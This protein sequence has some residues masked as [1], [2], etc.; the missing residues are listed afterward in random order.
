M[1]CDCPDVLSEFNL[2]YIITNIFYYTKDSLYYSYVIQLI[3]VS[4]GYL[5]FGKG[6]Y[7]KTLLVASCTGLAGAVL[8]KI[9]VVWTD[10]P[11][12]AD[13]EFI[14]ILLLLNEPCWIITEFAIPYL[15]M[16]KLNAVLAKNRQLTLK[17]FTLITFILFSIFRFRIG[18]LRFSSHTV[19][20]EEIFHAH[21]FSFG[22]MATTEF[23]FSIF[24]IKKMTKDVKMAKERGVDGNIYDKS[25][26]SSLTILLL[27]DICG[28]ILAILSM[29]SNDTL[30]K[31]LKPF[32]CI[33]SNSI[34]ILAFDSIV[35]KL[36]AKNNGFSTTNTRDNSNQ[37][38]TETSN[39][40]QTIDNGYYNSYINE[41]PNK[42]EVH[43]ND[44]KLNTEKL[45][46]IN[47]Q[48]LNNISNLAYLPNNGSNSSLNS[49]PMTTFS[50]NT[51]KEIGII[52]TSNKNTSENF[53]KYAR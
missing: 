3:L 33:K 7:W 40:F 14:Y 47:E 11:K 18:Y 35:L 21:G 45:G 2:G 28:I 9:C 34:L 6:K 44:Q 39:F 26:K 19:F 22:T 16:I 5:R 24:I 20:N 52:Y 41:L 8:E 31:I 15:N 32:H 49:I 10:H 51:N 42:N 4:Y 50:A 36:D 53:S 23:V 1:G 37:K 38:Y 43:K 13:D 17:I 27:I 48:K 12:N 30:E 25:R 46:N 29:F